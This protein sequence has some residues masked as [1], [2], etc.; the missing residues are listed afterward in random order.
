[1]VP[2]IEA[3]REMQDKKLV[4]IGNGPQL[5]GIRRVV[6]Q[7]VTL[8]G[9]QQS[10]VLRDYMQ[11]AQALIFAAEEVCGIVCVEAQA[12]G[13]PVTVFGK[14]GAL[15]TISGLNSVEPTGVFFNEQSVVAIQEAVQKFERERLAYQCGSMPKQR[16]SVWN[17]PFQ[18]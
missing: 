11:R 6:P 16:P 4:D 17:F 5:E 3:F 12:C 7:N 9:F 14:G 10:S 15:E 1:M 18:V 8:F 13:T 2:I